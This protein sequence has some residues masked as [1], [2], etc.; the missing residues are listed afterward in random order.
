[1]EAIC[2]AGGL[3][4]GV[5]VF[6]AIHFSFTWKCSWLMELLWGVDFDPKKS[7]LGEIKDGEIFKPKKKSSSR[8]NYGE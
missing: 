4:S 3:Q 5:V 8:G 6:G 1:M 2:Q 7:P